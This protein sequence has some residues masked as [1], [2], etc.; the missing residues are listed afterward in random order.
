MAY[1]KINWQN[2]PSAETPINADNLNHMDDQIAKNEQKISELETEVDDLGDGKVSKS[3]DTIRGRLTIDQQSGNSGLWLGNDIAQGNTGASRGLILLYGLNQY[4]GQIY[5]GY[6]LTANRDYYLPDKSGTL[7]I[8]TWEKLTIP[9]PIVSAD[10]KTRTY[11]IDL[12]AYDEVKFDPYINLY[13][14]IGVQRIGVGETRRIQYKDNAEY[15][16]AC[17][18]DVTATSIVIETQDVSFQ[19]SSFYVIIRDNTLYAR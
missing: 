13:A 5:D 8:T 4:F 18:I 1:T 17:K 2:S 15:T 19:P 16:W 7:A 10:G 3:G 11:N 9:T 14:G 12:S 6:G